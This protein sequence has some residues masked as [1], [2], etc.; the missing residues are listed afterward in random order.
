MS[1]QSKP[2][3]TAYI[4]AFTAIY[5]IWGSTYLGIRVAVETIP[6]FLMAGMRFAIAGVLV[7][8]VL[9]LRGAAWPTA[10][11]WRD[12][13]VAGIFLLLGGNALVTWSEQTVTSGV[14]SLIAGSSPLMV[15]FLEWIRPG[16]RRPTWG[17]IAGVLVGITGIALL[18]GPGAIPA[19]YRP[20][21]HG[22]IA[23]FF[24]SACWWIGSF[25]SKHCK[26]GT[27]LLVASSMQM[28][29]GSFTMLL[30][31]I[32]LGGDGGEARACTCILTSS[33]EE[34]GVRGQS[35]ITSTFRITASC[36]ISSRPRLGEDGCATMYTR[37]PSRALR[38]PAASRFSSAA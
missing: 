29:T 10:V 17:L 15:V 35:P 2:S 5:V 32:L 26:S 13:S 27:P 4:L 9:K 7:F 21:A 11:Q 25:Y 30:T 14:A 34:P 19:G 8:T 20:P 28:I 31:G 16:G 6:P 23:L 37:V 38:C 12:Q 24:A 3:R 33:F 22:L 36:V 1:L 18:L